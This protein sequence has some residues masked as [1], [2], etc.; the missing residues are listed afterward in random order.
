MLCGECRALTNV[1]KSFGGNKHLPNKWRTEIGDPNTGLDE[2]G[3]GKLCWD[4]IELQHPILS[5]RH[6]HTQVMSSI[7]RLMLYCALPRAECTGCASWRCRQHSAE[8]S[9][10]RLDILGPLC[11]TKTSREH[12]GE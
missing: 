3:L 2:Q 9:R 12:G 8:R 1:H 10:L 7:W 4:V 5:Q 6:T 11:P